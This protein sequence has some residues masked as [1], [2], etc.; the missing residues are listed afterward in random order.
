M[1]TIYSKEWSSHGLLMF[2]KAMKYREN[3]L[4]Y[5]LTVHILQIKYVT[6]HLILPVIINW[7]TAQLL[8]EL[9]CFP[10]LHD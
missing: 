7:L 10:D 9:I 3:Y 4:L 6:V 8:K 1:Q 2:L 5:I